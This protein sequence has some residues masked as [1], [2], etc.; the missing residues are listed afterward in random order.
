MHSAGRIRNGS[1]SRNAIFSFASNSAR[2]GVRERDLPG[3]R[4][5]RREPQRG[6]RGP[7]RPTEADL[8]ELSAPLPEDEAASAGALLPRTP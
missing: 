8:L 2:P 7:G 6:A 4:L 3:Q 1:S 5:H